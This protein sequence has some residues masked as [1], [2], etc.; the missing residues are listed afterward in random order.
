MFES[1]YILQATTMKGM[2]KDGEELV[3]GNINSCFLTVT[4][5][6]DI[7]VRWV[8]EKGGRLIESLC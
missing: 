3:S 1:G 4:G 5:S 6:A 7:R 8:W 2:V